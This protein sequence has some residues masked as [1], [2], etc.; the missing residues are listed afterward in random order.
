MQTK[1]QTPS[2][3]A[4]SA[5]PTVRPAVDIHENKDELLL[6]VDLPGVHQD[7]VF[8]DLDQDTLTITGNRPESPP[9]GSRVLAGQAFGWDFKRQFTVPADIDQDRIKANLEA[10]VLEV[11]LPRHERAKPR[12]IAIGS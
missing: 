7:Q 11:R 2:T 3:E 6:V 8:I 1:N 12:R 4:V 9:E 5:R 10:G